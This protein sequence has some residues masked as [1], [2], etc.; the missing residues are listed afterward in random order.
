MKRT[1]RFARFN[2]LVRGVGHLTGVIPKVVDDGTR[3]FSFTP[4][5]GRLYRLQW[6]PKDDEMELTLV[7]AGK[8]PLEV[9]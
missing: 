3:T 5:S 9:G 1:Q 8:R 4:E 2:G 7:E 6:T